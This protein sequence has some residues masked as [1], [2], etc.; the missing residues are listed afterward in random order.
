MR[1]CVRT[2]VRACVCACVCDCLGI[3]R[4]PPQD[5]L[6]GGLVATHS[7]IT[8]SEEPAS[9]ALLCRSHQEKADI[10]PFHYRFGLWPALLGARQMPVMY[11][12]AALPGPL[13]MQPTPPPLATPDPSS[14]KLLSRC[15]TSATFH[16]RATCLKRPPDHAAST[17]ITPTTTLEDSKLSQTGIIPNN[18]VLTQPT[19]PTRRPP[20]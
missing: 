18:H 4:G 14:N 16:C 19:C 10:S 8:S 5:T 3:E 1:V 12:R 7:Y 2:C 9:T 11:Y 13:Q 17:T 20:V 15:R 6:L